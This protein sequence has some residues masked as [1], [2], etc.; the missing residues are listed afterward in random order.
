MSSDISIIEILDSSSEDE[1]ES[2]T[3]NDQKPD[4]KKLDLEAIAPTSVPSI[5]IDSNP[6]DAS[7]PDLDDAKGDVNNTENN[8]K[9]NDSSSNSSNEDESESTNHG[10][11]FI[12]PFGK[13]Y[14]DI[15]TDS[16]EN[17]QKVIDA[18]QVM[19]KRYDVPINWNTFRLH[20]RKLSSRYDG[21]SLEKFIQNY[22]NK[23]EEDANLE[24]C[25]SKKRNTVNLIT[26]TRRSK[27]YRRQNKTLDKTIDIKNDSEEG[28][29]KVIDSIRKLEDK[30]IKITYENFRVHN[31]EL[32]LD[33]TRR[34]LEKFL[35]EHRV[36]DSGSSSCSSYGSSSEDE[37]EKSNIEES[38]SASSSGKLQI[39]K[40]GILK[41]E[42]IAK[43]EK[44][45]YDAE[46]SLK[47]F[48]LSEVMFIEPP[49][50]NEKVD[51][52][53]LAIANNLN[54]DGFHCPQ[55]LKSL[56]TIPT[57]EVNAYLAKL[58]MKFG[59]RLMFKSWLR[60][61]EEH[62]HYINE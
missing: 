26:P 8:D 29:K 6:Q 59:H 23:V 32:S 24:S 49:Y 42:K 21:T 48:L 19:M 25:S 12:P 33:Y 35:Y 45:Y 39:D 15:N 27:R 61:P 43:K 38:D 20:Y 7:M 40:K 50:R 2:E 22:L 17:Q 28:Q 51:E 11:A 55:I 18:I 47:E 30:G 13:S 4:E 10:L 5:N 56:R 37:D 16:Q 31:R 34:S 41:Q 62:R 36:D 52:M 14:M 54:K 57:L 44:E 3:K 60:S 9:E 58:G 1:S 46:T 53:F